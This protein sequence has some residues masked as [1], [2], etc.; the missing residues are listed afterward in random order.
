MTPADEP[1]YSATAAAELLGLSRQRF[2][3]IAR[4]LGLGR[5]IQPRGRAYS[6][7]DI[8][9]VRTRPRGR[10]GRPRRQPAPP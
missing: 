5:P 7:A 2:E 8:E 10:P 4:T 6:M 3:R 1:L 9:A